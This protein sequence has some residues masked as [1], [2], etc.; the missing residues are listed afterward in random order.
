MNIGSDLS[1]ISHSVT[2]TFM[3]P[4]KATNTDLAR[5]ILLPSMGMNQFMG[6]S[7]KARLYIGQHPGQGGM[8]KNQNNP[9]QTNDDTANIGAFASDKGTR[10]LGRIT[11]DI[12][13]IW[14]AGVGGESLTGSSSGGSLGRMLASKGI[15]ASAGSSATG[16]SSPNNIFE[17][18]PGLSG[19]SGGQ[20]NS[21]MNMM[22]TDPN[23]YNANA[24]DLA[25]QG[26]NG[27]SNLLHVT[28]DELNQLKSTGKI[29]TN[30][31]TGLPEAFNLSNVFGGGGSTGILGP[32]LGAAGGQ[33]NNSNNLDIAGQASNA[34][35]P[36]TAPQRQ[37]FQGQLNNLMSPNGAQNF[38][39]TDPSVQA[40]KQMIGD[41]MGA[42]F[43]KSGNMNNTAIMGSAQL[44]NAF[45][46]QYNQRIQ[47][48]T[49][50]GG[51]N[52]GNPYGGM[53][54]SA[55]MP[56]NNTNNNNSLSGLGS[57]LP[58]LGRMFG[59][60]SGG[61]GLVGAGGGLSNNGIDSITNSGEFGLAGF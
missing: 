6:D 56:L 40:Q 57:M 32:L 1:K 44:A 61:G 34:S 47:D 54:Y 39:Q 7:G 36:L 30:P 14:G 11:G 16:S 31:N 27:D 5:N 41:Q 55:A 43:G 23:L 51:Y 17:A 10:N 35:N 4:G 3:H 18:A 13:A 19:S 9:D 46:G 29:T 20:Q 59:G 25:S 38:M 58:S 49:T 45:G 15:N 24:Q 37:G 60:G 2:D 21:M 50:L 22:G 52:Q 12:A 42:T 48:L 53:P 33:A 8:F 26:R 28:D